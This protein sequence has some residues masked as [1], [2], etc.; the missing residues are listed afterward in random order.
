MT[1]QPNTR[2]TTESA[3]LRYIF[4]IL[5]N[6]FKK[7]VEEQGGIWKIHSANFENIFQGMLT[8][9]M[10]STLEGWPYIYE[11]IVDSNNSSSVIIIIIRFMI[12]FQG[13]TFN[14]NFTIG[15][16]FCVIF[17]CVGSFFF[18]NLFVGVLFNEYNTQL[19][20]EKK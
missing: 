20:K 1:T 5:K 4:L 14:N 6:N 3:K 2:N 15:S 18:M 13:P 8:L 17:I 9:F 10:L 19:K 7:C 11:N 16:I 12:R